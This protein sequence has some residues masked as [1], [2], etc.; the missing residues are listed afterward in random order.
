MSQK[1]STRNCFFLYIRDLSMLMKIQTCQSALFKAANI[2]RDSFKIGFLGHFN[3]RSF[4]IEI[5]NLRLTLT[6]KHE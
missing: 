1:L 2:R 4:S 3:S 6:R 5:Y